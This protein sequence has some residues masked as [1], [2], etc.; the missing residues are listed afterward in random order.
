MP[1]LSESN[2][3]QGSDRAQANV[4]DVVSGLRKVLWHIHQKRL[5]T[6][7]L[8]KAA[9]LV[10]ARPGSHYYVAAATNPV[11]DRPG[12]L[13]ETDAGPTMHGSE[14]SLVA[15]VAAWKLLWKEVPGVW[16]IRGRVAI[17][18]PLS[19]WLVYVLWTHSRSN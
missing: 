8:H 4:L 10:H 3:T 19:E 15:Q 9:S 12:D 7:R 2:E 13:T 16:Q 6:S 18:A 17:S 1:R 5:E 11:A 14:W